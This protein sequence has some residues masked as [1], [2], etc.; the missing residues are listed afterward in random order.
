MV[1]EKEGFEVERVFKVIDKMY[2]EGVLKDY[3]VGG[4]VATIYYTEPFATKDIDIFFIPVE[5]EKIILLTPFYEFLLK[6]GYKTY[7]EYIMIGETPIQFIPVASEL[8]REAVEK[9]ISVKY[10]NI[11]I[12]ILRPEYL[13]AIFLEVYRPKDKDKMIKLLEQAKID[14][15][16]LQDILAKHNLDK[17]FNDFRV[18]YYG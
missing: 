13:I 17:K 18:K 2:Q 10:R 3:A 11:Q 5:K 8:E 9:A 1:R 14:K 15:T 12:K 7:K 16:F 6:K 4:A